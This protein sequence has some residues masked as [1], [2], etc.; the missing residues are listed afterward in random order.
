MPLDRA[1]QFV[2]SNAV[3]AL[4]LA[5]V[6]ATISRIFRH[7]PLTRALWIL[8]LLKLLTP[9]IWTIPIGWPATPVA[10][11][12]NTHTTPFAIAE[13][14]PISDEPLDIDEPSTF[15]PELVTPAPAPIWPVVVPPVSATNPKIPQL[16]WPAILCLLWL[17]GAI[18]YFALILRSTLRIRRLLSHSVPAPLAIRQ[19]ALH[20]SRSMSLGR[21]PEVAFVRGPVP[22]MLCAIGLRPRIIL[23]ASLWSRLDEA[24][25]DTVLVHELA[26]LRHG[27]HW[28]RRLELLATIIYWW[29][30]AVWL[31]RS[32]LR[33]S[34]EQCCDAWVVW[35][36]PRLAR[37]YASA[38]IETVDFISLTRPSLPVL[39]SGM[40]Q[41]TDL[42][43]RLVM[44]NQQSARRALSRPGLAAVCSFAGLL[45]PLAPS[46]AQETPLVPP[47]PLSPP[48]QIES[49]APVAPVAPAAPESPKANILIAPVPTSSEAEEA[50]PRST[51]NRAELDQARAEVTKLR[52]QLR[53]AERHLNDIQRNYS[54]ADADN[55]RSKALTEA[56]KERSKAMAEAQKER[57]KAMA[58]AARD[59]ENARRDQQNAARDQQNAAED[60][61]RA[62]L[63]RLS[64]M[65]DQQNVNQDQNDPRART[66]FRSQ[67]D[68]KPITRAER[69]IDVRTNTDDVVRAGAKIRAAAGTRQQGDAG[70]SDAMERRL[71][72]MEKQ[73]NE[74]ITQ[75][76]QMKK[77]TTQSGQPTPRNFDFQ[78][79]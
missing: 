71:D 42:R 52:E 76:R 6:A 67:T 1:L 26:H 65:R 28:V 79:K 16:S 12:S 10:S 57:A 46:F 9:P 43:R 74:M 60:Q 27:D 44:I 29:H 54:R 15:G 31:S 68:Q 48:A 73:L 35:T 50:D 40:G 7:P 17:T 24:Q 63:D 19:R 14:T 77:Q 22:P 36:L 5:L 45:L 32:Q 56:Q 25:Q 53:N 70:S 3:A 30:P 78:E 55:A 4:G 51:Q 47:A 62:A 33:E 21:C 34:S 41:F 11:L 13:I 39:A 49:I 8:V 23:P 75:L 58:Q 69:R 64:A 37:S 72:Q 61:K 59:R 2:L 38:L 66:F 20:L 18:V